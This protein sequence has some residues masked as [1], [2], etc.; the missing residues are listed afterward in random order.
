MP[1][2]LQILGL[3]PGA[4]PEDIKAAHRKLAARYHPD[5]YTG[6][7]AKRQA[8]EVFIQI[9]NARDAALVH[10]NDLELYATLKGEPF[11]TKFQQRSADAVRAW[12]EA[13]QAPSIAKARAASKA[14]D[15][16]LEL[17]K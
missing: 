3:K 14:V 16:L 13:H 17:F 11:F 1:N 8:T 2:A 15:A 7:V 9:T 6:E 10:G 4:T 12:Q 5:K